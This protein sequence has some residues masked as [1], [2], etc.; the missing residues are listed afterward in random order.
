MIGELVTCYNKSCGQKFN[1]D[2]N[3]D[4][5][6]QYHPGVPVFHDALKGWSCCKKRS[7]DFS[8]FL[9]IPGCTFGKHNNEKP[10][11]EPQVEKNKEVLPGCQSPSPVP[12][13]VHKPIEAPEI[14]P[15]LD[16]TRKELPIKTT[17]S[18]NKEKATQ[19]K[20]EVDTDEIKI[21]TMCKNKGCNTCYTGTGADDS[22]C[23]Y[24]PGTAV[25]HEGMKYWSCC[26]RKTSDF[27]AFLNQQ[28]CTR[29]IHVW[30]SKEDQIVKCRYDYHQTGNNVTLT[31]FAKNA[32]AEASKFFA[33]PISL[34]A[35]VWFDGGKRFDVAVE[36]DGVIKVE[37]SKVTVSG[38]K[39]EIQMRKNRLGG[40]K[41]YGKEIEVTQQNDAVKQ[42]EKL[43]ETAA[44]EAAAAQKPKGPSKRDHKKNE[45]EDLYSDDS[46]SGID[47][48]E[49]D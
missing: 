36:L 12:P 22:V 29:G 32:N 47:D 6:C 3:K 44:D 11:N 8:E 16:T 40:W 2:E 33:N 9:S 19:V 49:F 45:D 38:T 15:K 24:H 27:N 10:K 13:V 17:S 28:G 4:K 25:F 34:V 7:T 48:V 30:K 18:Y 37:E 31:I 41:K 26:Q 46:L 14:R 35:N 20:Q 39:I 42:M 43:Q 5:A 23:I 21:G 1:L